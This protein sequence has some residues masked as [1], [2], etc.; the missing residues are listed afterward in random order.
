MNLHNLGLI[1]LGQC[2][3]EREQLLIMLPPGYFIECHLDPLRPP[4]RF[5]ARANCFRSLWPQ[6]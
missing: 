2:F 5:L 3:I 6:P 4:S 1:E